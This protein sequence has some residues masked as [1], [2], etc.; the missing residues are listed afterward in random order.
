MGRVLR[1]TCWVLVCVLAACGDRRNT[2]SVDGALELAPGSL[3]FQ[4]VA[5]HDQRSLPLTL[6]N[7]GR[8]RLDLTGV[9]I[10]GAS[11]TT[12]RFS[13]PGQNAILPGQTVQGEVVFQP[14]AAGPASGTLLVTTDSTSSPQASVGLKGVGVDAL[15]SLREDALDFGKI[16]IGSEKIRQ[17][18]L[19]NPST[20]PVEVSGRIVGAGADEFS[21]SPVTLA[22]GETRTQD[23]SFHPQRPGVKRAALAV[24]PCKGCGDVLVTLTGEGL[25]QALIA[26]P[27]SVDFGL[28]PT[29]FTVTGAAVLK[30]LSTEP[31]TVTAI[32]FA[33]G[34]DPDFQSGGT[35]VPLVIA[36]G[37]TATV[38]LAYVSTHLDAANGTLVLSENSVRHPTLNV[39]LTGVG[40]GTKVCVAPLLLEFGKH[41]VGTRTDSQVTVRNCGGPGY[42]FTVDSAT[43]LAGAGSQ[44]QLDPP[45]AYPVTLTTGNS[46]VIP[47]AFVPTVSGDVVE[48]LQI[49]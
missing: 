44:F 17:L 33:T 1:R 14:G 3:D 15:A 48:Q 13:V 40:G 19:T 28:V 22:P 10:Q 6:R 23:V 39:P 20:L 49:S 34:S 32:A 7:S 36:G 46:V 35:P 24:T 21:M 43:L 30:N 29:D 5:V 16:G 38:D 18:T 4:Q 42:V 11:G 9:T 37:A 41:A 27:A 8:G 47:V 25:E 26:D 31:V 45:V 2:V 12:F